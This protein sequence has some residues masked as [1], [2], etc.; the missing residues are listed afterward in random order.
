MSSDRRVLILTATDRRRGAEV[1]TERLQNGLVD[2]GWVSR[3]RSLTSSGDVRRVAIEAITD[4]SSAEPGRLNITILRA[5][6]QAVASFRPNVVVANGGLT[7]RY[8]ALIK[9]RAS[10][11]LAY[12]AIGEPDYWIRSPLSRLGNRWLLRRTDSILAVCEATRQQLLRIEPRTESKTNVTYTAVPD[13]LFEIRQTQ[14][15]GWLRI[16]VLGSLSEEKDPVLALAVVAGFPRSTL[17][18]VGSGPLEQRLQSE[19]D[20]LGLGKRVQIV[21]SAEDVSPYLEW[22]DVLLLTSRTEGLPGAVLEAGAASVP[23][24]GVDVGGVSEAID[25]GVT[26]IVVPRDVG[27][28][29]RALSALDADS[30]G[31]TRMGRAARAH[32]ERRF[33]WDRVIDAYSSQLEA[34]LR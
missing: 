11:A 34:M 19:I 32:V 8:A 2:R 27:A 26:G 30:D 33:S 17:R 31:L 28:L 6:R 9:G 21:G 5:L 14:R 4:V 18:F 1:F 10:P 22:A 25:D 20:R 23:A 3:S 7:L 12:I 13:E 24:L 29:V 15:D 16:L